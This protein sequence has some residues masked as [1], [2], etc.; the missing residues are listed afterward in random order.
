MFEA[1]LCP[2]CGAGPARSYPALMAPFIADHVLGA[3]PGRA[4]LLAC[5]ACGF[6]WFKDRFDAAETSRLY[7][8][9]RGEAYFAARR[10]HEF[11]YTR[12]V[13][14]SGG[15]PAA[16]AARRAAVL[17]AVADWGGGTVERVL[18]YG[19]DRGQF[20][21]PELGRE[22]VVYEISGAEPVAGVRLAKSRAELGA[23]GFDLVLCS[24]VLEHVSDPGALMDELR[25][26]GRPGALI[27]LSVPWER[28]S[29]AC[30]PCRGALRSAYEAWLGLMLAAGPLSTAV[31]FVSVGC[32]VKLGLVPPLGFVKLH[33]HINFFGPDS[34]RALLAGHGLEVV[35]CRPTLNPG[36][37]SYATS[38]S[39]AA[40]NP[41]GA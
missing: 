29:L 4:E 1:L 12:G 25:A 19:G 16:V 9:Y 37:A 17:A 22:R 18:D 28:F 40:R 20:M 14:G 8:G 39:C 13:N 27:V 41:P 7:A 10:R 23:G 3:R 36:L 24:N 5:G 33:E 15:A 21:P 35:D 38:L 11:W 26:L 30:V 2:C 32:K 6:R 31:D 34:L